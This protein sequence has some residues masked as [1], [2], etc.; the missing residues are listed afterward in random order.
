MKNVNKIFGKIGTC[1][2]LKC[3]FSTSHR[4][5]NLDRNIPLEIFQFS[6]VSYNSIVKMAL[7]ARGSSQNLVYSITPPSTHAP[8]C[9]D[10]ILVIIKSARNDSLQREGDPAHFD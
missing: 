4:Q 8:S 7:Q 2:H 6:K 3:E 5:F 10:S 1:K 9:K